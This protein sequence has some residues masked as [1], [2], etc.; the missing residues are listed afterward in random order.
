[1]ISIWMAFI[2]DLALGDPLWYPH[3]VI[4][5]GKYIGTFEKKVRK[6]IHSP[7]GL[8]ISGIILVI[9]TFS[10]TVGIG[11]FILW[12]SK[13]LHFILYELISVVLIWNCFALKCLSQE[14]MK[15]FRALD[16]GDIEQARIQLS[17][18]VARETKW[19]NEE[20]I[21]R[22]AVE[23]IVENASDGVIAPMFYM[24]LGGPVLGL[25]YKAIN[26]MD[27][28]VGYKNEKYEDFGKSAAVID[29]IANFI[30]ARIT[31]LLIVAAAAVFK[32]D[33]K[34]AWKI[35]IRDRRKHK[36]PNAGYPEA[37]AAGALNIE[38]GG[39][40]IYFGETVYKPTIGE[41]IRPPQY[42]DIKK[43]VQLLYGSSFLAL[44]F[45]TVAVVMF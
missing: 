8:F 43:A 22:A 40:N 41:N 10:I 15:I 9:T 11:L 17:Y 2:L 20:Q 29:D 35:L 16:R 37:A 1:M 26:T 21:T 32:M 30:P 31:G 25:G 39:S 4:A 36:S 42:E 23:T 45:L 14:A 28:M 12:I 33:Y 6:Y 5:M 38:L 18:L 27:S 7:K 34:S 3:P 24:F 44:G 13:I 19:L